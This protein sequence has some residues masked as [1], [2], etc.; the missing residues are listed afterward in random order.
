MWTT[1][2]IC[3]RKSLQLC[4]NFFTDCYNNFLCYPCH[5]TELCRKEET[6]KERCDNKEDRNFNKHVVI[7]CRNSLVNCHTNK[8]RTYKRDSRSNKHDNAGK[9]H[10]PCIRLNPL[11]HSWNNAKIEF[12]FYFFISIKF[13]SCHN[14]APDKHPDNNLACS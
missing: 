1:V 10:P 7:G 13:I 11:E 5:Q 3:K 2:K 8:I 6:N 12:L 4:K 9:N 14:S